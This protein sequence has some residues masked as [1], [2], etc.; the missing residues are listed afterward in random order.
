MVAASSSQRFWVGTE[1]S[2]QLDLETLVR[3]FGASHKH[4]LF[5]L[6]PESA[7]NITSIEVYGY[8]DIEAVEITICLSSDLTF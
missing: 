2:W 7:K 8:T 6:F 5:Q 4:R 3:C 1:D